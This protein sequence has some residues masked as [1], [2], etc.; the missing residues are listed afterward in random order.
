MTIH[1]SLDT[2]PTADPVDR[3]TSV[4]R[5]SFGF[6]IAYDFPMRTLL[7]DIDGTLLI[8]HGGGATALQEAMADAFGIENPNTDIA[9]GGRTD[10]SILTELLC[11]NGLEDSQSN[12]NLLQDQYVARFPSVMNRVGGQM[13][14]GVMP[15]LETVA[16]EKSFRPYIMTGNF[17]IT[18]G[19]K[20]DHFGLG[21]FFRGIFGGDHD[22]DRDHLAKRTADALVQRYGSDASR[23]LIVI[24]DT[25]ADIRCGHAI[26]ANVIAVCTGWQSR[27]E[28]EQE[29]PLAVLDDL[30]DLNEVMKWIGV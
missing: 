13:C 23:D 20:L 24:G 2:N 5:I 15:L 27:E 22:S 7:F 25:I 1:H 11:I 8:T 17:Q 26:G 16:S 12:R 4:K 14:P 3:A 29:K 9:F 30:N 18:G 19:H 10:R 21:K 6:P 28:L